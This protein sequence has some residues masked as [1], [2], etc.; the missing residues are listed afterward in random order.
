[1][2]VDSQDPIV[3]GKDH[4]ETTE[5]TA[6]LQTT[7]FSHCFGCQS[8]STICP[9][10]AGF[11][12]PEKDLTLLPH[13]MMYSL[14]LGMTDAAMNSAM[15]WNCLTCYQCQETCPQNVAVCDIIF[16]LKNR[17][18]NDGKDKQS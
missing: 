16:L 18:F 10:V 7:T 12:L 11:D 2:P 8:C 5:Q 4:T 15:I 3:I 1:M 13:Q 17:A 9:V 14:G 6:L